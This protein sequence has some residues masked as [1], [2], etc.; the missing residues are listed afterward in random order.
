M[1]HDIP[2]LDLHYR[3]TVVIFPFVNSEQRH[4]EH[5]HEY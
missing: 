4:D 3:S 1:R 5:A 2:Y